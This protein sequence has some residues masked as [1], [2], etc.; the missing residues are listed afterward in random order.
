LLLERTTTDRKSIPQIG[1]YGSLCEGV[2]ASIDLRKDDV[3]FRILGEHI[4]AA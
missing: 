4:R 3:I 1:S 2:F